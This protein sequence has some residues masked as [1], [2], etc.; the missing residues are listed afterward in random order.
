MSLPNLMRYGSIVVSY[1]GSHRHETLFQVNL[2]AW[3]V[4]SDQCLNVVT[5]GIARNP[6]NYFL[7]VDDICPDDSS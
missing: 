5:T 4:G 2:G 3:L 6:R 1:L 7:S